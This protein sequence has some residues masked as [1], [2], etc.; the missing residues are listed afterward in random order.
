MSDTTFRECDTRAL[1]HQIGVSNIMSISG[2]RFISR[3]TGVTL[4]VGAGYKVTVD[5][6]F[7]DTYTVRRIFA[8]GSKIWIKG[9]ESNVYAD[10]VGD[11]AYRASCYVNVDFGQEA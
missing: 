10:Q 5:L 4:P 1:L 3:S 8:R 11:S 7:D 2:M 6:A 9:E